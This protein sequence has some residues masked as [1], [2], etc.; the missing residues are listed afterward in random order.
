M[1]DPCCPNCGCYILQT[2]LAE[3]AIVAAETRQQQLRE[4]IRLLSLDCACGCSDDDH[5][6][7]G[8]DGRSCEHEDHQCVQTSRP[9]LKMLQQ[10]RAQLASSEAR[11]PHWQPMETAPMSGHILV[12]TGQLCFVVRWDDISRHWIQGTMVVYPTGW[13]ALPVASSSETDGVHGVVNR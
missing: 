10:L 4:D 6:N 1:S 2:A 5:E 12:T 9:V 3:A 7:Y 8:E 11:I 13:M